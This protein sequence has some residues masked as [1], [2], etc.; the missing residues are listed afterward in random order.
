MSG[1]IGDHSVT[2]MEQ[3]TLKIIV[4][5]PGDPIHSM[6]AFTVEIQDEG[7]GEFIVVGTNDCENGEQAGLRIEADDWPSLRGAID[8]MAAE[9]R[10]I[11]E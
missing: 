4:A 2:K 7:N 10:R 11:D 3:R 5:P 9:V 8:R 6:T 1:T